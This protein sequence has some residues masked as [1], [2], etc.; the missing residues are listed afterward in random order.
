[1]GHTA[2]SF[3]GKVITIRSPEVFVRESSFIVCF[4]FNRR[5]QCVN[6]FNKKS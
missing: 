3:I 2:L 4:K 5:T 1:M 6:W